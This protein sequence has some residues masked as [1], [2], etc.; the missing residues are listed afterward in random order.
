M[1]CS[2]SN[3]HDQLIVLLVAVE[4]LLLSISVVI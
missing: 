3:S 1:E 4:G 2:L